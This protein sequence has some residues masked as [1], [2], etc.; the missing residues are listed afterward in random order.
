MASPFRHPK[1]ERKRLRRRAKNLL[2]YVEPVGAKYPEMGEALLRS[3][4]DRIKSANAKR[5]KKKSSTN[6]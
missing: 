5:R 1:K 4:S 3:V 2:K 6:I